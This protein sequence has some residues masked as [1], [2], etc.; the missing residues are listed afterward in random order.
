MIHQRQCLTFSLESGDDTPSVHSRFNHFQGDVSVNRLCLLGHENDTAPSFSN[1]LQQLVPID[2]VSG[3]LPS[4]DYGP[5][6]AER[7]GGGRF[8]EIPCSVIGPKQ[9]LHPETQFLVVSAGLIQKSNSL[10]IRKLNRL[11]E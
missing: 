11:R 10:L 1:L 7:T 3:L 6:L 5:L 9:L 4:S 2:Q 8:E